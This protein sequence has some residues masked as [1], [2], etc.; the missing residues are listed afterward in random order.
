MAKAV[1]GQKNRRLHTVV[2]PTKYMGICF[3]PADVAE[4]AFCGVG[5]L[6]VETGILQL[7][8]HFFRPVI[9]DA[10]ADK[11]AI[12]CQQGTDG[13]CQRNDDME[14]MSPIST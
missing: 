8:G 4:P 3:L 9:D 10:G 11:H 2:K 13:R 7:A 5:F 6:N 14:R 12:F 1:E